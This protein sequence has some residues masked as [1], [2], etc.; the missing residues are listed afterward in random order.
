MALR[1]LFKAS[2]EQ[3]TN[4]VVQFQLTTL[5][6]G[7]FV[8]AGQIITDSDNMTFIYLM[9]N[10]ENYSYVFFEQDVWPQLVEVIASEDPV[11]R[12]GEQQAVLHNFR[13]ELEG[14]IYNIE[15]NSN[16]GEAFSQAVEQAFTSILSEA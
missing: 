8:P 3:T 4:A 10:G 11:L 15:G 1:N 2:Y 6:E 9:D 16:Y 5:P 13:D 14:L 12:W 7:R